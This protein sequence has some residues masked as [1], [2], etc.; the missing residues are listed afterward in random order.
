MHALESVAWIEESKNKSLKCLRTHHDKRDTMAAL[1]HLLSLLER[2]E[3]GKEYPFV[4]EDLGRKQSFV[5]ICV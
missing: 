3:T 2:K 5:Q 4:E 1:N